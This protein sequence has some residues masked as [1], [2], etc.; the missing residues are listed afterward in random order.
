MTNFKW[1]EVTN[2]GTLC[3]LGNWLADNE[4]ARLLLLLFQKCNDMKGQRLV[5]FSLFFSNEPSQ[6]GRK[7]GFFYFFPRPPPENSCISL[8]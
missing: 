8:V 2:A 5:W 6:L 4:H 1:M 7:S 3:C